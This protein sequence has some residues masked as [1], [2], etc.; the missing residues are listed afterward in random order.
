VLDRGAV[1]G[2]RSVHDL[3]QLLNLQPDSSV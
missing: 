3:P 1:Y 2:L